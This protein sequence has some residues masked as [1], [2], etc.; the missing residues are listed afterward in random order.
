MNQESFDQE[1][2]F[3]NYSYSNIILFIIFKVHERIHTGERPYAC[4]YCEYR[5]ADGP[6]LGKHIKQR[7]K[8]QLQM[9][10][11]LYEPVKNID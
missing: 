6:N 8:N 7:H 9:Q 11:A 2:L 3:R 4:S 5:S 1:I 10:H